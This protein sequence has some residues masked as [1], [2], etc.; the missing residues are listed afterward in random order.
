MKRKYPLTY[1]E[2]DKPL[3]KGVIG[4]FDPSARPYVPAGTL[5]F[6]APV[7]KFIAMVGNMEESFLI[8][9]SW[10]KVQARV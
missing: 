9:P 1:R 10:K 6:A 3:P 5:T 2:K 4:L 7:A 8:T